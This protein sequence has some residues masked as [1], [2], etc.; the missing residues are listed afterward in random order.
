[1]TRAQ[2]EELDRLFAKPNPYSRWLNRERRHGRQSGRLFSDTGLSL[3]E[4]ALGWQVAKSFADERQ[5][6]PPCIS[7]ALWRRANQYLLNPG[8]ADL[9]LA[10]AHML[11]LPSS[12]PQSTVLQALMLC[13]G[14]TC[15]N[16][17]PLCEL[18]LEVIQCYDSLF[19]NVLD[20]KQ[21]WHYVDRIYP[22]SGPAAA[23]DGSQINLLSL[24]RESRS[25]DAVPERGGFSASRAPTSSIG[26]AIPTDPA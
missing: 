3:F 6:L 12:R 26:W 7:P 8:P 14:P 4:P 9:P 16:L 23:R 25:V 20:R 13:E 11:S 10:L 19:W 22:R 18:E 21:D 1:M 15:E 5:L 2:I 17:A 24:A